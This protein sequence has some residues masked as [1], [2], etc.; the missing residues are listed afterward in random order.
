MNFLLV[1]LDISIQQ[2]VKKKTKLRYKY[3]SVYNGD[4]FRKSIYG[5]IIKHFY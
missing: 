5:L 2:K 4:V 3:E 1:R